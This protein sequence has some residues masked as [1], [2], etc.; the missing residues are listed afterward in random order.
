ML[1]NKIEKNQLKNNKNIW[2]ELTCQAR[3]SSH[4]IG[5]TI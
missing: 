5:I 1:K 2:P 3:D 4:E